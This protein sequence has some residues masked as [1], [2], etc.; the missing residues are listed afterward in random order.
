MKTISKFI[1]EHTTFVLALLITIF[2]IVIMVFIPEKTNVKFDFLM[3]GILWLLIC[4]M[5]FLDTLLS[6]T[7]NK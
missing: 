7:K 4:L 5:Y 3:I 1:K 2:R 6:K